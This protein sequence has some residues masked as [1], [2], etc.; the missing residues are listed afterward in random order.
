MVNPP[1]KN[2]AKELG[3]LANEMITFDQDKK[4]LRAEVYQYTTL[5]DGNK[6]VYTNEDELKEY[7]TRGIL[8]PASV[9]FYS[10]FINGVLQ[11]KV[12]YEIQEGLLLLKTNDAPPKNSTIILSFITILK[13]ENEVAHLNSALAE[14]FLPTGPISIGPVTDTGVNVVEEIYPYL[15]IEKH[16]LLGPNTLQVDVPAFWEYQIKVTNIGDIPI[17]NTVLI[18]T[19]LLDSVFNVE[20]FAYS[21]LTQN[22]VITW[23]IGLLNPG[24]VLP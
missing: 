22:K 11:P 4:L 7:G 17:T 13:E 9:T 5:S 2:N 10:L 1:F 12:N 8:D 23:E 20:I 16:F 18:E 14:G 21:Q 19:L 15:K 24:K 6:K 3:I